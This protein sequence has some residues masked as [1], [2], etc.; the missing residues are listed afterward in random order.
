MMAA[1]RRSPAACAAVT[2]TTLRPTTSTT[3]STLPSL[4]VTGA[5][6]FAGMGVE[7][8]SAFESRVEVSFRLVRSG[9]AL[10]GSWFSDQ[11]A[12]GYGTMTADD[13]FTFAL[14]GTARHFPCVVTGLVLDAMDLAR[15]APA[16]LTATAE[17]PQGACA[18]EWTGTLVKLAP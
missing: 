1:C 15:G 2:T 10:S 13:A 8:C 12:T 16:R 18:G 7:T 6:R 11:S 3:S 17:C 9:T 4:D 14:D 5:W